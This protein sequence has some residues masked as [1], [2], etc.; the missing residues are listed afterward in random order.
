MGSRASSMRPCT[1]CRSEEDPGMPASYLCLA[2][3]VCMYMYV[4]TLHYYIALPYITLYYTTFQ[5]ITVQYITLRKLQTLQTYIR[6][7]IHTY[8]HTYTY[9]RHGA[10][11]TQADGMQVES[12]LQ[13]L[14]R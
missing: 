14:C 6:T 5:Y 4:H 12:Q 3:F 1:T 7:Y 9:T 8:I 2:L 10:S 13:V 11:R